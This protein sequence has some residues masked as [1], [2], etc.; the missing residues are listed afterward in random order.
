MFH[1]KSTRSVFIIKNKERIYNL[2]YCEIF[3]YYIAI[4]DSYKIEYL[5]TPIYIYI[6]FMDSYINMCVYVTMHTRETLKFKKNENN[7]KRI[8][9]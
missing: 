4:Y 6:K 3:M 5:V 1:I 8:I 2:V 9:Q 7:F